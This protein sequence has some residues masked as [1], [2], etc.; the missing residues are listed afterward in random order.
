MSEQGSS[1]ARPRRAATVFIFITI[2]L[3]VL[4]L[5]MVIPVMPQ[6]ITR[7]GHLDETQTL[8]WLAVFGTAW[9]IMQLIASPVQGALS[10]RFGRRPVILASNFGMGANYLFMALAPNLI[11]L[12]VG[13]LISGICSGSIPAAMAYL[14]DVN[15]P[16][17]R[18]ASFGLMGGA[19][20]LGFAIG[21]VI[22]GLLGGMDPRAP[23]WAAAALS[24]LN[25]LYG[26]F[27]LPESLPRERRA[28]L[29]LRHM[30]PVGAIRALL[31]TYPAI[32]GM[33]AVSALMSLAQMGP[34]NIF[35]VY[36]QHRYHWGPPEVGLFMTGSG[37]A[38]M[39]VQTLMVQ[40]VVKRLGERNALIIGGGLQ[41]T[42]FAILAVAMTGTQFWMAIPFMCL[43]SIGG[44][45]WSAILSR[46]V[47]PSEQGL[48]AGA[49]SSLNSLTSIISPTLFT[50]VFAA[51]IAKGSI[52][53]DGSPF[54]LAGAAM[55]VAIGLAAWVTRRRPAMA[56]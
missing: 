39:V 29:Q 36:T 16:E 52:L 47:G 13:R 40:P 49:T 25:F 41:M 5:G 17:K 32:G 26:V 22:G 53:P 51:A 7:I 1:Q 23:F 55:I 9:A 4:A 50:M 18:A 44:P 20:S 31:L 28:P 43:A 34:Y 45:A 42:A 15:P 6:L 37:V 19:L 8:T 2:V 21:P 46:T 33:L 56:V 30:N 3:D 14:A 54:W 35:V 48:L 38:G 12:F 24:L 11:W 10:D 27:V